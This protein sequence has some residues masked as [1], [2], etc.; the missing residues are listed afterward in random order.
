MPRL[1]RAA[2]FAE[3]FRQALHL[4]GNTRG[5]KNKLLSKLVTCR[6]VECTHVEQNGFYNRAHLQI[7][8]GLS[9]SK[10]THPSDAR[11]KPT[12]GH[13]YRGDSDC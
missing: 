2:S 6:Q 3:A 13:L 4:G 9:L 12:L 10:M 11:S 8:R 5:L 7:R 1:V